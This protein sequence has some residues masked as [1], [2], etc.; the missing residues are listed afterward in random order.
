MKQEMTETELLAVVKSEIA[1]SLNSDGDYLYKNREK[2]LDYYYGRKNGGLAAP[3]GKGRSSVVSLEIMDTIGWILPSLLKIF[4]TSENFVEFS[5][6]KQADEQG[7]DQATKWC[8]YVINSKN[9]GFLIFHDWFKDALLQGIGVVKTWYDKGDDKVKENYVSVSLEQL[10]LMLQSGD[11]QIVSQSQNDDMTYDIEILKTNN[12]GC[13]R[14]ENVPPDEF[15]FNAKARSVERIF[16]CYHKV[17]RTLTELK[18]AGYKNV[19]EIASDID[20]GLLKVSYDI[21]NEASFN[22]N[23]NDINK[24]NRLVYITES[25]LQVDF[26]GDGLAEWRKVVSCGTRILENE[27]VDG[28]PFSVL[29]PI[30]MPHQL[31]GL[32]ISDIL[33]DL[34]EIKTAL[35]RQTIDAVFLSNYPRYEVDETKG[36]NIDDLLD[37]RVGGV[38]RTKGAGGIIPL[39]SNGASPQ[40]FTMLEYIDQMKEVRTGINKTFQGLNADT[41]NTNSTATATNAM[42]G[43]AQEKIELIARLF[44]ETGL[45]DL[46]KKILKLSSQHENKSQILRVTGKYV[47]IDPRSWSNE[48]D[49]IVNVGLGSGDKTKISMQLMQ[50]MQLQKE[51][52]LNGL[53]I[54]SVKEIYNAASQYVQSI[55]L[56][57]SDDYLINPDSEDA[58]KL[59]QNKAEPKIDPQIEKIKAEIELSKVK[60]Q[61]E[62]LLQQAKYDK[63]YMLMEKRQYHDAE[64]AKFNAELEKQTELKKA[65]ITTQGEIVVAQIRANTQVPDLSAINQDLQNELTQSESLSNV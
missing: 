17:Q 31:I 57:N 64:F 63:E 15:G 21:N 33:F 11:I 6:R 48:Y 53:P 24:E 49:I 59:Q 4:T 47:E 62:M 29:T 26:D 8:N 13:V 35:I 32:S 44:A 23:N 9:D 46:F 2:S 38:V 3:D 54:V 51:A 36:V 1:N 61:N 42:M 52:M 56:K 50:L 7:A 34:Q 60:T 16:S 39:G 41:L 65:E 55:G 58:K 45:K 30:K 27:E 18:N 37:I 5:P 10:T 43:A 19:D 28:H 25:Y 40:V 22:H 14:I 20:N 12:Y